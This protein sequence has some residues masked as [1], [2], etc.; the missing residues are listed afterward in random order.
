[1]PSLRAI[2]RMTLLSTTPM[3]SSATPRNDRSQR[4][5][6]AVVR[7]SLKVVFSDIPDSMD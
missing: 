4:A 3:R 7:P 5:S 6:Q 2:Q 1:M